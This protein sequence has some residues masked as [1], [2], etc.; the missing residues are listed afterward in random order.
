MGDQR[1]FISHASEDEAVVNRIVAYLEANGVAC[2]ISSRD[3]PPR[4]IYAEAITDGMERC[5]AC[6]V[7][8][9]EAANASDAV[10][11][12]LELASH[13]KKPFVPIRIDATEPGRGLAYYLRNTQWIDYRREGERALDR[14]VGGHIPSTFDTRRAKK[15]GKRLPFVAIAIVVV[16]VLVA[17]VAY[18]VATP[19][20]ADAVL[21]RATPPD[22]EAVAMTVR[23]Q[24]QSFWLGNA[25]NEIA[26]AVQERNRPPIAAALVPSCADALEQQRLTAIFVALRR[27]GLQPHQIYTTECSTG[28]DIVRIALDWDR[29]VGDGLWQQFMGGWR[30]VSGAACVAQI[31]EFGT[32]ADGFYWAT[33]NESGL[34]TQAVGSA[35]RV[36]PDRIQV[37]SEAAA[38]TWSFEVI[39]GHLLVF[40]IDGD[41]SASICEYRRI[42][43]R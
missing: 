1:L 7:V 30:K 4:S 2:W 26:L 28:R 38:S 21:T 37:G 5:S 6:A 3:I 40:D 16:A 23:F 15:S 18:Q 33:R 36:G 34:H 25:A 43:S 22:A 10:K 19:D 39:D 8:V 11:R 27:G 13:Y 29:R 35:L 31:F 12:E 14:I 9:S 17:V 24:Q 32:G 20:D 42:A 41:P